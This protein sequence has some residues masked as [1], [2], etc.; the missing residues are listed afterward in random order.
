RLRRVGRAE[1]G[2]DG[3]ADVG[4]G[5]VDRRAGGDAAA[6]VQRALLDVRQQ[7]RQEAPAVGRGRVVVVAGAGACGQVALGIVEAVAGDAE[8]FEV[9]LTAHACGGLADLLDGGQQQ[10]DQDGYDGYHHQKLDQCERGPASTR[11]RTPLFRKTDE[12]GGRPA[13][14]SFLQGDVILPGRG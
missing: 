2:F 11:H 1:E 3:R 8:L 12:N 7:P 9:V 10:A 13:D 6:L 4:D 5:L 14:E